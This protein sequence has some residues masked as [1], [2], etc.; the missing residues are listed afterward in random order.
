MLTWQLCIP[1]VIRIFFTSGCVSIGMH[2]GAGLWKTLTCPLLPLTLNCTVF[3]LR[4]DQHPLRTRYLLLMA[5]LLLLFFTFSA[6]AIQPCLSPMV[7][8]TLCRT[9]DPLSLIVTIGI[10]FNTSSCTAEM[11]SEINLILVL[12]MLSESGFPS[13]YFFDEIF[14]NG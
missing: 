11:K 12:E 4:S 7:T 3:G 2:W 9:Y 10:T 5:S 14:E 8:K 1:A 13:N 6:R